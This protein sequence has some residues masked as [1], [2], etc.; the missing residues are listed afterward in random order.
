VSTK[1]IADG[2][3]L[4]EEVISSI[5]TAHAFGTQHA[6]ALKYQEYVVQACQA[7]YSA[8]LYQGVGIGSIFFAISASYSLGARVLCYSNVRIPA[9]AHYRSTAFSFGTTL[10]NKGI[11]QLYSIVLW[12]C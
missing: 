7:D 6:L 9:F 5:R 1:H 10:I 4:V 11:G 3:S 2:G 8:A 12:I